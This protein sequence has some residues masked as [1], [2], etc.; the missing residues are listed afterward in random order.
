MDDRT[1][2]PNVLQVSY[3][4]RFWNLPHT[5]IE[6][7]LIVKCFWVYLNFSCSKLSEMFLRW[8]CVFPAP[9]SWNLAGIHE[10]LARIG[11][12]RFIPGALH[13]PPWTSPVI[14]LSLSIGIPPPTPPPA[15]FSSAQYSTMLVFLSL[16]L[17]H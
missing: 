12:V 16:Y 13:L 6:G 7:R 4:G 5:R 11:E 15:V 3:A 1:S 10:P 9:S 14:I 2:F 8:M 17:Y